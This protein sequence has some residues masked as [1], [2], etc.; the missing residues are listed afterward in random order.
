MTMTAPLAI[1]GF[2][3]TSMLLWALAAVVPIL[4]HLWF[5]RRYQVLPWAAVQFLLAAVRA[6][7][8]RI[9][10]EQ[11]ILLAVRV[12]ILLLL[13]LA[14]ADPYLE[15][16]TQLGP[17]LVAR[18]RLHTVLVLDGS[19]SMAAAEAEQSRFEQA[20]AAAVQIVSAANQGDAF[21]LV[22]LADPPQVIVSEPAFEPSDVI[23][24]IDALRMPH[25]AAALPPTLAHVERILTAA[26]KRQKRLAKHRVCILTDLQQRTWSAAERPAV[27]QQ[28]GRLAELATLELIDVGGGR[29]ENL[30]VTG[31]QQS[32]PVVTPM[33]GVEFTAEVQNFGG[34]QRSAAVEFFLDGRRIHNES[35]D[36]PPG[37]RATARAVHR[38]DASGEHT[39]EVRL[40]P[41]VLELDNHRWASVPVRPAIRALCVAGKQGA[42]DFVALALQ[43]SRAEN[44]RI[45]AR[46]VTENALLEEDVG[47]WDC[48]FLCKGR[49][50]DQECLCR[51]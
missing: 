43:P 41:D 12:G 22:L 26:H 18:P 16:L 11:L 51:L 31:L 24:E 50:G 40:G 14:L 36:V 19:Y 46:V 13:A 9:R 29:G 35:V 30:A 25:G 8:R 7:A 27:R 23:E 37:G 1:T 38:F 3:S 28:L 2:G 49:T 4:I 44:P 15:Q 34:Q 33:H 39:L 17:S 21:T 42:A 6:R 32:P 10:L 47:Q 20:R 5:K 45:E 48:I